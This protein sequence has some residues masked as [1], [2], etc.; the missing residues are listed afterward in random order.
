MK[1]K[2]SPLQKFVWERRC[3]KGS[4]T[5]IRNNAKHLMS[6]KHIPYERDNLKKIIY[7]ASGI[8]RNWELSHKSLRQKMED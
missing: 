1:N 6:L 5:R 2:R 8:L 3:L 7:A 4:V